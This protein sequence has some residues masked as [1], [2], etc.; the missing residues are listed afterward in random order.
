MEITCCVLG[1][2]YYTV[3]LVHLVVKIISEQREKQNH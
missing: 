1:V 3:V 2:V